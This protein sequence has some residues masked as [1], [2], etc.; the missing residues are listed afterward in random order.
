[1]IEFLSGFVS[2]S[3]LC[4]LCIILEQI[5]IIVKSEVKKS[6]PEYMLMSQTKYDYMKNNPDI[7]K[8]IIEQPQTPQLYSEKDD[9]LILIKVPPPQPPLTKLA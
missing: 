7:K 2:S 1:M 8:I 6:E 5:Y 9:S 4:S 3:L